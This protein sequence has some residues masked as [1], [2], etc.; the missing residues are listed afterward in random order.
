L[1]VVIY[2]Y[3]LPWHWSVYQATTHGKLLNGKRRK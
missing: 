2:N 3:N 1:L